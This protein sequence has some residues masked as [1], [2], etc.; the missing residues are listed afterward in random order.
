ML[1]CLDHQNMFD[2]ASLLFNKNPAFSPALGTFI[3]QLILL[4][5]LTT[6]YRTNRSFTDRPALF[7]WNRSSIF[8]TSCDTGC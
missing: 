2:H 8:P 5:Q 1:S 7:S 6:Q 4:A 3:L